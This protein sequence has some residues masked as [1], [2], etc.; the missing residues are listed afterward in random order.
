MRH[1]NWAEARSHRAL[2]LEA[3]IP[4]SVLCGSVAEVLT[5]QPVGRAG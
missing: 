2:I 1:R 4:R 3:D 5:P